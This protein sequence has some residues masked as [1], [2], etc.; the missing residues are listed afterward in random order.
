[1]SCFRETFFVRRKN[2]RLAPE[3][4]FRV[5]AVLFFAGTQAILAGTNAPTGTFAD[6]N[7]VPEVPMVVSNPLLSLIARIQTDSLAEVVMGTTNGSAAIQTNLDAPVDPLVQ[8]LETARY[9]RKM[10]QTKDVEPLL[11][12]LLGNDVPEQIKKSALL[13]LAALAQ[14]EDDLPRAQQICAQYMNRWPEDTRIPEVLLRQGEIFRQMGLHNMALTKFYAVMTAALTLK[15]DRLD[16]YEHLVVQAQTEIADT[17]FSLGKYADAAEYYSRLF[18]QDNPEIDKP[19]ILYKLVRCYGN[20]TNYDETV[21]SAQDYLARYANSPDEAE[22]RFDLALA[23]KGLGRDS[24]SLQQVLTL[25]Q[26]QSAHAAASPDAWA[27]WRQRAGNLIANQFYREGDYLR[28]LDIY[29]SLAQLD[30]SPQWQLP[31]WY[32]I[33]MTYEHLMQPQKAG[34]IYSQIVTRQTGLG[35]NA[36]PSIASIAD[37]ARWR[38]GFIKW[39]SS[40]ETVNHRFADTN[41]T[42]T[43]TAAKPPSNHE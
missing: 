4:I 10:R 8:K 2:R 34:E 19:Q 16:Y 11:V 3:S 12:S 20:T 35:T 24:E 37:M 6:T 29:T 21:A 43:A 39:Q 14:D 15:N 1:M 7:P 22:V 25:L 42:F 40:A 41:T 26:E 9:L 23:L 5:M 18:K 28:A 27:Y 13:E 30:A 36:P 38:L 32:Q 17:H 31:V 33:G